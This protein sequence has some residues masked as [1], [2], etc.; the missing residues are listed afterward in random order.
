PPSPLLNMSSALA[1]SA[2]T[3]AIA[4]SS[5]ALAS[6]AVPDWVWASAAPAKAIA[7]ESAPIVLRRI[8]FLLSPSNVPAYGEQWCFVRGR[9]LHKQGFVRIPPSRLMEII[10]RPPPV[11]ISTIE[12]R[13]Y[14]P[15]KPANAVSSLFL[16]LLHDNGRL[17]CSRSLVDPLP[18]LCQRTQHRG[19]DPRR[20]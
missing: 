7:H 5:I 12:M 8:S 15:I 20:G 17:C 4:F 19:L 1:L 9:S 18:D 14:A 2:L 11:T 10:S 6:A 3:A 13:S 16:P